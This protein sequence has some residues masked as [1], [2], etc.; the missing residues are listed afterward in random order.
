MCFLLWTC[1]TTDPVISLASLPSRIHCSSL[2]QLCWLPWRSNG[3]LMSVFRSNFDY[4]PKIADLTYSSVKTVHLADLPLPRCTAGW[5]RWGGRYWATK[6]YAQGWALFLGG[7]DGVTDPVFSLRVCE[8]WEPRRTVSN[9]SQ[10][11]DVN[12]LPRAAEGSSLS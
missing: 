3:P 8:R 7:V 2:F 12:V 5:Q 11:R 9:T 10:T 6:L 4:I 1:C